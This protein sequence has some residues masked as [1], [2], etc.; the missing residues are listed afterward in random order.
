MAEIILI[1]L[2]GVKADFIGGLEM[3]AVPLI[4]PVAMTSLEYARRLKGFFIRKAAKDHGTKKLIEGESIADRRVIILDDVT[5][6]GGSAMEAVY[7]ARNAGAT[8]VLVLSIVDREEGAGKFFQDQGVE[9]K[10]L[11]RASEFRQA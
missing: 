7:E 10:S 5:T 1:E 11:F 2:Q 4:S 6:S 3:G 9:F 8:V